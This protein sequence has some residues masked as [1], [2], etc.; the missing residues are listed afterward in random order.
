MFVAL[1][2]KIDTVLPRA[3][4]A[5]VEKIGAVFCP[6]VKG[7]QCAVLF[8]L[9]RSE[10]WGTASIKSRTRLSRFDAGHEHG[11]QT[12]EFAA[13]E[14]LRAVAARNVYPALHERNKRI[15]RNMK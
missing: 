15:A 13:H 7:F 14:Q 10:N 4:F 5:R 9:R 1:P 2:R 11:K 8:H 3:N 12:N 6:A